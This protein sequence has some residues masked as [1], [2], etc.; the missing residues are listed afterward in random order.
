M[1]N[2]SEKSG[3]RP[4]RSRNLVVRLVREFARNNWALSLEQISGFAGGARETERYGQAYSLW[5]AIEDLIGLGVIAT[6]DGQEF[7]WVG[8]PEKPD[9]PQMPDSI[10]GESRRG[11]PGGGDGGGSGGSDGTDDGGRGFVEVIEHPILF[12]VPEEDFDRL[13]DRVL[14][15]DEDGQ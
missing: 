8:Y 4:R 15:A 10:A 13:L 11:P 5:L 14:M 1:P 9:R 12:C 2:R 7:R 3:G 6:D